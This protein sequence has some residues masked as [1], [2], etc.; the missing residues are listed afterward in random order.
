MAEDF[1][2]RFI[3][4]ARLALTSDRLPELGLDH[5]EGAFRVRPLVVMRHELFAVQAVIVEHLIRC[6]DE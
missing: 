1:T 6:S 2:E 4:A 3:D 5:G